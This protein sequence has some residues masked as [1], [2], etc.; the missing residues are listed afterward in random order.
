[1]ISGNINKFISS[2]ISIAALTIA[3][4]S[5][6]YCYGWGQ[7]LFYGYPWWHVQIGNASMARSLTYVFSA[8]VVLFLSYAMGYCIVN[9]VFKTH[10]FKYL[11][12]LKVIV[13]VSVFSVPLF[14]TCYLFLG[15]IPLYFIVIYAFITL[16]CIT[17]FQHKWDNT[18][19]QLDFRKMLQKRYFGI[20]H[21]FLLIYFSLLSLLIGY[22]RADLRE[23]YDYMFL[24]GKKYYILS[25]NRDNGYIL[26]EKTKDNESFLMFNMDTQQYFRLYVVKITH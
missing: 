14:L 1:M 4:I 6:A 11:G 10:Y 25:T 16:I 5:T 22:L 19:F 17:L 24:E 15:S 20:F 3:G 9:R 8:S 13:L 26:A 12:W 18:V 23:T 21:L 2:S 7:S